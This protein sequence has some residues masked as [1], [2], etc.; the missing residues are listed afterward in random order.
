MRKDIEMTRMTVKI[1]KIRKEKLQAIAEE[2]G[3]SLTALVLTSLNKI[4]EKE[5]IKKSVNNG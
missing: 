2:Q 1:P 4:I 5:E 3:L